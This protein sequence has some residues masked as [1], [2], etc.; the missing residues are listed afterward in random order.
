MASHAAIFVK[1]TI[2]VYIFVDTFWNKVKAYR[3]DFVENGAKLYWRARI[4]FGFHSTNFHRTHSFSKELCGYLL[5]HIEYK[6]VKKYGQWMWKLIYAHRKIWPPLSRFLQNSLCS[7]TL[8]NNSYTEFRN[9]RSQREWPRGLRRV[10]SAERLLGSWV[11]IQP[12][13]WMF[14]PCQYC[15]LSGRGLCDRPI[16]RP[17]E[18][19]RV[20]CV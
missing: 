1:I 4:E 14:V 11:R 15:V 10:P 8:L 2:T 17:G 5:Y 9:S 16:T 7:V 18:S 12:V 19:Y 13:A 3:V 6:W 20:W